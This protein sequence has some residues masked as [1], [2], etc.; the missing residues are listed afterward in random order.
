MWKSSN[1]L[2][3]KQSSRLNNDATHGKSHE[4]YDIV[5]SIVVLFVILY[6]PGGMILIITISHV[7]IY[8]CRL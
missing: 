7:L 5:K 4:Y 8:P 1:S 2:A 6:S 3:L